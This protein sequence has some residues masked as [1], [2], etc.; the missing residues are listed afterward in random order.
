MKFFKNFTFTFILFSIV[1]IIKNEH[2]SSFLKFYKLNPENNTKYIKNKLRKSFPNFKQN[3]NK[4][5][6]DDTDLNS[7][8]SSKNFQGFENYNRKNN[9][10]EIDFDNIDQQPDQKLILK[11]IMR[12]SQ[13]RNIINQMKQKSK[14]K[15]LLPKEIH[16]NYEVI[17]KV[18]EQI[19]INKNSIFFQ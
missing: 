16:T 9:I 10:K 15:I 5:F 6:Y 19:T 18:P 13:T 2:I 1:I 4:I 8:L 17:R 11:N 14:N 3:D 12:D 7:E